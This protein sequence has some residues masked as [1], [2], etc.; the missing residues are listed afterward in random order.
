MKR[1]LILS[2]LMFAGSVFAQNYTRDAGIRVGDYFSAT[3]R[4]YPDDEHATEVMLFIG[5]GGATLTILKE[6]FTPA[7]RHISENLYF[8]HGFGA[9]LGFRYLNHYKVLNRTYQL[10]DWRFTPL[11][12]VN[13]LIGLEYRF[14]D[15]PVM[16]GFDMKPYFEYSSIQIF[17]IY[18]KSVGVSIKYRF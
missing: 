18:L 1:I 10:E 7:L 2:G 4:Q 13:G 5:R 8:Q 15:F 17:S 11:L 3:Y 9:H 12:G 14:P 6:Y 16:V